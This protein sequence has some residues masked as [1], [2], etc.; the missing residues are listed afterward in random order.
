MVIDVRGEIDLATADLLARA[1]EQ[2]DDRVGRVVVD[3][4]GVSFLDSSA[5]NVLVRCKR[6]LDRREIALR[7]V[8]PGPVVRRVFEFTHLSDRLHVVDSLNDALA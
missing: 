3:L 6:L 5:L 4:S 2:V 8:S 1:V 7:V